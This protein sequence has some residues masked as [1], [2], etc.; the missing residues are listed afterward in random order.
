MRTFLVFGHFWFLDKRGE[1]GVKIDKG[2]NEQKAYRMAANEHLA[3][4]RSETKRAVGFLSRLLGTREDAL[5][6]AADSFNSAAKQFKSIQDW[7]NTAIAFKEMGECLMLATHRE[8][9]AGTAF[10]NAAHAMI[11]SGNGTDAIRLLQENVIPLFREAASLL[12]MAKVRVELAQLL[13]ADDALQ[14]AIDEYR[15]A[16][17]L[18]E[19]ENQMFPVRQTRVKVAELLTRIPDY[20]GAAEM[21]ESVGHLCVDSPMQKFDAR[22]HWMNAVLC[23]LAYGDIVA[24]DAAMNRFQEMDCKF[25]GTPDHRVLLDILQAFKDVNVT[26]FITAIANYDAIHKLDPWRTQTLLVIKRQIQSPE[27]PE[28]DLR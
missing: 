3:V 9:E 19:A 7:E 24:A 4:A 18:F 12:E 13:D 21:F 10:R 20:G 27:S 26:E 25:P 14:P 8:L 6:S 5:D 15:E 22:N 11:K 28:L 16:I 23:M 17:R 2:P 1:N